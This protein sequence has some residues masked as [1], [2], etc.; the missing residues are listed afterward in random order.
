MLSGKDP[1]ELGCYGFRNRADYSYDAMVTANGNAIRE[2]RVWD[3]LSRQGKQC[4]VVGVP[5]TYP[6]RPLNGFLVSGMDTPDASADYTYPKSL[7]K[8][9]E[10]AVG[11]YIPDVRN[12]RTEN[13]AEL[14][15]RIYALMENRFAVANHLMKT[16]PWDFCMMVEMGVDRLH[17]AFW[18]YCD[19]SHPKYVEGNEFENVFRDYYRAVDARIGELLST[20]GNSTTVFIVSDHGAK[21]MRGGLRLNQWLINEGYLRLAAPAAP[22]TRFED[23]EIDW[24]NTQ[25]WS[26]GGYYARVFLNVAGR[27]PQGCVQPKTYE[28]LRDEIAEKV[29][30]ICGPDGVLLRNKVLKPE[31]IY[32]QVNGIPPDLLVYPDD[33]DWRAIGTV[34]HDSIYADENDTGPDDANHDYDGIFVTNITDVELEL[35]SPLPPIKSMYD[36]ILSVFRVFQ[37]NL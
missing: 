6:P 11:E 36:R 20:A 19:P 37:V 33:L 17:H 31:S 23:C 8:E 28:S 1:G 13:K 14:L 15:T 3:V 7:K 26:A 2:P 32:R 30:A 16:K 34:G 18:K 22:G 10:R 4:I 21:A 29:A 35:L 25:A 27:E 24:S 12:F 9:I 5:Q